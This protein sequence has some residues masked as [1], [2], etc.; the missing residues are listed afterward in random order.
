MNNPENKTVFFK[1]YVDTY[2]KEIQSSINFI[3][4]DVD[5]FIGLKADLIVNI[6]HRHLGNIETARVLDIGSGIGL[7]DHHLTPYFK[8]LCGVDVEEEV[9]NSAKGFNS[10]VKY[11]FYD[12][13]KLPFEDNSIDL[14]FSINVMHH[15]S[16][17]NWEHF[18][19][20]MNR[21]LKPGGIGA[22]FEHNPLNPLTRLAVSK[23]EFDRDANL[24]HKSKLRKMFMQTG[25]EISESNYIVFF[26]FKS[27]L[28]RTAEKAIGWLPFGA[29]FYIAGR[30]K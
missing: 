19:K 6:A 14:A 28:F 5:F 27:V 8:N 22:V 4:Q 9:V 24:L 18:L 26:P 29:Q 12:G 20:E 3:G 11:S 1:D 25:F 13:L 17:V 2:Q 7:T 10:E 23:C 16:P 21:V 30:K 15:V